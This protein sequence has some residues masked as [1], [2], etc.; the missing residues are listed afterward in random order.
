VSPAVVACCEEVLHGTPRRQLGVEQLVSVGLDDQERIALGALVKVLLRNTF[1]PRFS[2]SFSSEGK[3]TPCGLT[4]LLQKIRCQ[5]QIFFTTHHT[6][7]KLF[8]PMPVKN[9]I[10]IF[11]KIAISAVRIGPKKTIA[12]PATTIQGQAVSIL[13][14]LKSSQSIIIISRTKRVNVIQLH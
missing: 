5:P 4:K 6:H 11:E 2:F 14:P 13:I 8:T 3:T 7:K 10:K 9:G 12:R 1:Q